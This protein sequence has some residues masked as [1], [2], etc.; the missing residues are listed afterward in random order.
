M[1]TPDLYKKQIQYKK[2]A[3]ILIV[4]IM[5]YLILVL[6]AIWYN[7]FRVEKSHTEYAPNQTVYFSDTTNVWNDNF[8][9]SYVYNGCI[10]LTHKQI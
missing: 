8:D 10:H 7:V 4:V 3:T 2:T 9:S 6:F 1:K 5:I